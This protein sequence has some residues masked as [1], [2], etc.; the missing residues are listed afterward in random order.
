[1]DKICKKCKSGVVDIPGNVC[2]VCK[3]EYRLKLYYNNKKKENGRRVHNRRNQRK[4]LNEELKNKPCMDC[5]RLLPHWMMD[6]DHTNGQ[7]KSNTMSRLIA[8]MNRNINIEI[9][10][11][12]LVCAI[13]HTYRTRKRRGVK[14]DERD[15]KLMNEYQSKLKISID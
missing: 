6:F 8:D 3:N 1:M 12:D 15:I 5:G 4:K 10:K 11:C 7:M 9:K 13:C 14:I 2:R